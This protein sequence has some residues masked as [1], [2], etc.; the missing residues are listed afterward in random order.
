M[1]DFSLDPRLK[2]DS[3]AL[4]ELELCTV[5]LAKDA[6]YPWLIMVPKVA[7]MV[8]L[9]DLS[10]QDQHKLTDEIALISS[11]LRSVTQCDK[12][13][14]AAL[15]NMVRQLHIHVIARFEEDGAWPG[16]IWGVLPAKTYDGADQETLITALQAGLA[17]S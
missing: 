4:C 11:L 15:G 8:E 3:L 16:P 9:I 17:Q 1:S 7:G 6:N 10:L 14:V 13:N 5:R 12:L 2:A